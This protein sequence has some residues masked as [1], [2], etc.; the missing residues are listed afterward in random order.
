MVNFIAELP[1][2][3]SHPDESHGKGWWTLHMDGTSRASGSGV[4]YETV[5]AKLDLALALAATKLEICNRLKK[6]DEWK[7][8]RIPQT[9]NLKVDTLAEMAT[10]LPI[11]EAVMLPI[12]LQTTSSI[13]P[14]SIF[15]TVEV[16]L[17]WMH[18]IVK[19]LQ[20]GELPKD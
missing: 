14:E 18:D 11:R 8:K 3:P 13:I 19:Y 20:L 10:T 12:Y 9:E 1:Q 2:K 7:V 5:L 16:D 6:L 15:N 17:N 4:E